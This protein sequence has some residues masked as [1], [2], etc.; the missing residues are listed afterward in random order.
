MRDQNYIK[1]LDWGYPVNYGKENVYEYD[2]VIVGGGIAGCNAAIQARKKGVSVAVL[3]KGP[4]KKSGSAGT[5]IDHWH[6]VHTSPASKVT[7]EEAVGE[8]MQDP[9]SGGKYCFGHMRYIECMESY[10]ALLDYEKWGI[11]FR[12]VDDEFKGAPFRDEETKILYAYNYDAKTV[13]RLRGGAMIKIVTK[14]ELDRSGADSYDYVMGVGLLT[15]GGKQGNKVVGVAGLSLRTGEFYIFKAKSVVICT[16]MPQGIWNQFYEMN[17]ATN[18]FHD[19]NSIGDSN[20]MAYKAGAEVTN[21]EASTTGLSLGPFG[22]QAYG[23]G[24]ICNTWFGARLV[25]ADGT[26]IETTFHGDPAGE[27]GSGNIAWISPE[28]QMADGGDKILDDTHSNV[29]AVGSVQG[30]VNHI[31]EKIR[32][33]ELKLPF[34]IDFPGMDP[35]ERRALWGLMLGNEGRTYYSVYSMANKY[36]FDPEKDMMQVPVLPPEA[37]EDC[38]WWNCSMMRPP[39][40]RDTPPVGMVPIFDWNLKTTLD[41][42]YVAG[43]LTGNNFGAGAATTGRYAGRNAAEYAKTIEQSAVDRKQIDTIKEQVYEPVTREDGIGWKEYKQGLARVMQEYCGDYKTDEVLKAGLE[44]LKNIK[45]SEGDELYARNPH[46]LARTVEAGFQYTL[47][48]MIFSASLARKCSEPWFM[49]NRLDYPDAD[50]KEWDKYITFKEIDGKPV[51]GE[52]PLAYWLKGAF[53]PDYKEN[54]EKHNA[55]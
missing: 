48:E 24:N 44:V 19:P 1:P 33:G 35:F 34:Y 5:G 10:E 47:S 52:V 26:L 14:A 11:P 42:L 54:Y 27:D 29:P 22:Y 15:E 6:G 30:H 8:Y 41:G 12:D 50:P 39:Q 17:G 2:V 40:L 13:V 28:K 25:D 53:A 16:G 18:R 46:E 21:F 23:P 4:I 55:M 31:V 43:Y 38:L 36:G 49:F 37:Y 32:S 3:D 7:P 45:E 20:A 51:A 9:V